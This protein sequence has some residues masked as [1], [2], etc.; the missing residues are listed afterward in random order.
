MIKAFRYLSLIEGTS[1]VVL[2]F[3]AMPL[4]YQMDIAGVVP[5][6]G[7]IHGILFM[8]YIAMTLVVSHRANWSIGFWLLTMLVSVVPFACLFLDRKLKRMD[9]AA[10]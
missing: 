2:L 9:A 6:V 8:A 1:L 7:W 10:Y 3:I 5:I 4:K